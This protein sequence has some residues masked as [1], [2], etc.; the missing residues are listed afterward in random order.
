MGLLDRGAGLDISDSNATLTNV[1]V[2]P[3]SSDA[4]PIPVQFNPTELGIDRGIHYAEFNVPGLQTPLLQFVRGDSPTLA[5]EL[6]LD[7]YDQRTSDDD[8]V[9]V[10]GRLRKIRQFVRVNAELH[11]PPVCRFDWQ[12]FHFTGVVTQLKE[13]YTL[14]DDQGKV[15][16][17]RV[18]L[19]LKKY[20]SPELQLRNPARRSPDRTRVRTVRERESLAQIANEAYGSPRLWRTIASANDIDRP[21]FV[22]PGT[23]LKIPAIT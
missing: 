7:G 20:A 6:L 15:L 8:S 19:T 3:N 1:S 17:A 21:R 14:F 16:R 2:D 22:A 18:T 9:T 5:L 10:A 12:D 4:E 13:K 11:A 23:P